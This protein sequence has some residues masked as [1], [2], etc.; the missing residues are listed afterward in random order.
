MGNG[1]NRMQILSGNGTYKYH[2]RELTTDVV[3]LDYDGDV[4]ALRMVACRLA[5]GFKRQV[6]GLAER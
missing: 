2:V 1:I 4:G 6:R 3:E 5:A